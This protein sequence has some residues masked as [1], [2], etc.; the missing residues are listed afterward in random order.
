MSEKETEK[1]FKDINSEELYNY[2]LDNYQK[3]IELIS[4]QY[5]YKPTEKIE[6]IAYEI[7]LSGYTNEID[8]TLA[9][10][11]YI[12]SNIETNKYG[13]NFVTLYQVC[14]GS[15]FNYKINRKV[16]QERPCES[17]DILKCIIRN[18][19][20]RVKN[21]NDEWVE[22]QEEETILKDYVIIKRLEDKPN[23]EKI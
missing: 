19:F 7:G 21:E 9:D 3:I 6:E 5:I 22:S 12:V 16:F 11:L 13:T 18:Q 1:L 23:E 10:N 8:E 20:K 15:T 4:K 2:I 17:G 14:S